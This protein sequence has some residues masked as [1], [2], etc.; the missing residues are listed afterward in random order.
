MV[1]DMTIELNQ[2][3][4]LTLA[5]VPGEQLNVFENIFVSFEKDFDGDLDK[6]SFKFTDGHYHTNGLVVHTK[7]PKIII[8]I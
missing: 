2:G 3:H 4:K 7:L 6:V 5:F 8:I 1:K